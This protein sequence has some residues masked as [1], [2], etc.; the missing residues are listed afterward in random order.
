MTKQLEFWSQAENLLQEQVMEA[1]SKWLAA[2]SASSSQQQQQ[3]QPLQEASSA[4]S[5]Q[6]VRPSS[7]KGPG[8]LVAD[9]EI[10]DT[11]SM[12]PC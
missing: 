3:Q 2:S 4:S 7:A 9:V 5:S 11:L 6:P 8:T 10:D 1:R 12:V